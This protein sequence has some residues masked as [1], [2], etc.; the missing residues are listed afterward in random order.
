MK[1]ILLVLAFMLANIFFLQTNAASDP[2][3]D[4]TYIDCVNGSDLRGEP[5][6]RTSPYLTLKA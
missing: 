6:N 3:A 4:Y 2:N 5:F 1:K